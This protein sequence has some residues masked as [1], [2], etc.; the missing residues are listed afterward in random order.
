M[1][2]SITDLER[3][4]VAY[5]T[6]LRSA[7]KRPLKRSEICA[8]FASQDPKLVNSTLDRLVSQGRL[9]LVEDQKDPSLRSG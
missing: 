9:K 2:P 4:I 8:W 7:R 5:V 1:N 3:A 6:G